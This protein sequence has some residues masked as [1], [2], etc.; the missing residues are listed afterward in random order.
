MDVRKKRE[1]PCIQNRSEARFLGS[2][3]KNQNSEKNIFQ[4]FLHSPCTCKNFSIK[5]FPRQSKLIIYI[6]L[7]YSYGNSFI[8]VCNKPSSSKV[9]YLVLLAVISSLRSCRLNYLC[10]RTRSA[11]KTKQC[12]NGRQRY[13]LN[14]SRKW[15]SAIYAIELEL[16]LEAHNFSTTCSESAFFKIKLRLRD[17]IS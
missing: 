17:T 1:L 9:E 15:S 16:E 13:K 14:I 8:L 7:H 4:V 5:T 6:T 3:S 12:G 11:D 2:E 10:S